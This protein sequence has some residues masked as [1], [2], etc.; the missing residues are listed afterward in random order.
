MLSGRLAQETS[1]ADKAEGALQAVT[2]ERD[3]LLT[4]VGSAPTSSRC[5]RCPRERDPLRPH[6]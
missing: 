4:D 3:R 5:R 1:R 6:R 2:A